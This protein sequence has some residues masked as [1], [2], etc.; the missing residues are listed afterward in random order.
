[1]KMKVE[2]GVVPLLTKAWQRR[3]ANHCRILDLEL[4]AS[5][6]VRRYISTV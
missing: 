4:L 1:M 3:P 2:V 6:T 5:K